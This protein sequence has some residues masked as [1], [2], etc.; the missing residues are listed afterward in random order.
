MICPKCGNKPLSFAGLLVT[1]NP[2]RIRC[3][4]CGA[5]LRLGPIGFVW[6]ALHVLLAFGLVRL[7]VVLAIGGVIDSPTGVV[8]FTAASLALIFMTAYVI[9]WMF[10]T[11]LYRAAD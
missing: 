9:P 4:N 10:L 6:T 1:L 3:V 2:W 5:P 11:H 7:Y 8:L